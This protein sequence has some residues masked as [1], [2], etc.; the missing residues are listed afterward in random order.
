LVFEVVFFF[1]SLTALGFWLIARDAIAGWRR[2]YRRR[3]VAVLLAGLEGGGIGRAE[4]ALGPPAEIVNGLGGRRLYVWKAPVAR[5][6]PRAEPLLIITLIVD[7]DGAVT[8]AN[9]EER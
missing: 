9:W 7:A 5:A 2:A 6:I 3:R 4:A 1:F 8:E